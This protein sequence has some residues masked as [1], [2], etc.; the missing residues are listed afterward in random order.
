MLFINVEYIKCQ[1]VNLRVLASKETN[2][3]K[4]LMKYIK[5]VSVILIHLRVFRIHPRAS[6]IKMTS[7]SQ[8]YVGKKLRLPRVSTVYVDLWT[9]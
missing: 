6:Y 4:I 8:F 7:I 2:D 3:P 5:E 1:Y 9:F